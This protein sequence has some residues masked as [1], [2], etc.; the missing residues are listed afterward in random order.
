MSGSKFV[1]REARL[2]DA[3]A[4]AHIYVEAWRDT[5]AGILPTRGLLAMDVERQAARWRSAISM[6]GREAVLVAESKDTVLGMA[7]LGRA[8]DSGLG[9]DGEIYTLYV[10]P[11]A[12]GNGIGRG[13]LR[14][15]F[16]E[17]ADRGYESCVIWAHAQ[18]P[19]RFFYQAM[20]GRL[21]AERTTS[22][23]G[24]TVPEAAFGWK[25]LALAETS[26]S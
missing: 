9:F 5:Y 21:I 14:T 18:N 4:I 13:L 1:V 23:M 7:S 17:L 26:R 25:S 20:G 24:A 11:L 15:G 8:R 10:H 16:D 19:A 2:G 22:M 3:Q 12:T 6:P